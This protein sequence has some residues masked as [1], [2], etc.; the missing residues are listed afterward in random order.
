MEGSQM[1]KNERFRNHISIV[2]ERMGK[3]FVVILALLV[4][5]IAQN[6]GEA[7]EL[8]EHGMKAG[9]EILPAMLA[10]WCSWSC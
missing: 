5:G 9:R 2:A 6:L 1:M 10:A 4:G 8:A 3:G 7:A